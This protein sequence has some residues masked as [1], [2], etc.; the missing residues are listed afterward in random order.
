M[1]FPL[2]LSVETVFLERIKNCDV[3]IEEKEVYSWLT[4]WLDFERYLHSNDNVGVVYWFS[5]F[6]VNLGQSRK[7]LAMAAEQDVNVNNLGHVK[8]R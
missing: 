8:E 3:G 5:C 1:R 2:I 6:R 7:D 4:T